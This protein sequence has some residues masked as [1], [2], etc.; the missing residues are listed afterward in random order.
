M[1]VHQVEVGEYWQGI[2]V[3]VLHWD[4][5]PLGGYASF[6]VLCNLAPNGADGILLA[7]GAYKQ[8]IVGA[9]IGHLGVGG[10]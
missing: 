7:D 2:V 3:I 8:L 1:Q 9:V 6:R 10:E 4:V 5:D